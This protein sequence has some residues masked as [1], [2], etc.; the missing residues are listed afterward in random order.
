MDTIL[1]FDDAI[2]DSGRF[3][4]RHL[5]LGN[6]FSIACRPTLFTYGS[7][8]EQADFSKAPKLPDVFKA[9]ETTDFEHVIKMLEDASRIVPIYS[10]AAAASK[11]MAADA[12]VLKG[13]LIQTV[14]NNHPN[15]PNEIGDEQF[16]ACRR[17]LSYFL[18]SA[19]KDGRVYTL[20][21]DLLLY[22]TLMHDDMGFSDPVVLAKNDGFGRDGDTEPEYVNWMGES[23]AHGQRVH[24]LHGALHLFDSGA[25]LQKYTWV[26][27]GKPLLDQARDAMERSKYPLFVSE[28]KSSQKLAKIKHSAYL[29]H[30]Y[31]SFSSQMMQR[32]DALFIFGH[33]LADNDQHIL[34]K[35]ARGKIKQIYVGLYGDPESLEN[36]KIRSAAAALAHSRGD[37]FP[38]KV[39]FFDSAS[40]HVW[41]LT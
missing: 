11:Q 17:F 20:N 15:I 25:E 40:A 35:I 32:E 34:K 6:G 29:Y 41:T 3:K 27:T 4:K 12:N 36:K 2:K 21:Y 10:G 31:K 14:A 1:T 26:N 38:L 22:W 5:L 37:T 7:L 30:S 18:G 24:Y 19:N 23:G 28:G 16:W 33:G 39:V 8:F 13:I 9:V